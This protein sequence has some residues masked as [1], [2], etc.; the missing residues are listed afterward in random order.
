MIWVVKGYCVGIFKFQTEGLVDHLLYYV[1]VP[2]Y[3][4]Y[5]IKTS[6]CT[7]AIRIKVPTYKV[8]KF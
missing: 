5:I 6:L 8:L 4:T 2:T 7:L 3:L 1:D